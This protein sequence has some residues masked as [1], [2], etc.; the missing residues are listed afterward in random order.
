MRYFLGV[1]K[2]FPIAALYGDM[3]WIPVWITHAFTVIK[4]YNSN[5]IANAVFQWSMTMAESGCK[6]WCW[7]VKQ[8]LVNTIE[9]PTLFS[10]DIPNGFSVTT[11]LSFIKNKLIDLA[12]RVW[13]DDLHRPVRNSESGGKLYNYKLIK[14]C[15]DTAGFVLAPLGPGQR[16][17]MASLCAGCLPLAVETGRYRIPKGPLGERV[18]KLC[19]NDKVK[20]EFHFV[21]ECSKLQNLRNELFFIITERDHTFMHLN[22]TDKFLYILNSEINTCTIAKFI[23][24]MYKLR[25][26][27]F[28]SHL[29][30]PFVI[31]F[32]HTFTITVTH[33]S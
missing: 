12:E 29:I 20:T 18:C 5:R 16:W 33:K 3:G 13:L 22:I 4:W 8:L 9:V 7:Q 15:A 31:F 21:M 24:K 32:H 19:N 28:I 1:G 11:T 23:Y 30:S 14:S 10:V 6:N 26:S 17:A 27:F 2:N 25:C